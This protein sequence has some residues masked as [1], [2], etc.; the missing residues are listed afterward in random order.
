[1]TTA[2][3]KSETN[4][5]TN[6]NNN[7]N[8]NTVNYLDLNKAHHFT[9]R[10]EIEEKEW[11]QLPKVEMR[12]RNSETGES[13][14]VKRPSWPRIKPV[15]QIGYEKLFYSKIVD[16]TTGTFYPERDIAGNT[17]VQPDG[18][19]NA[20]YIVHNIIRLKSFSGQEY[21]Y[22]TGTAVGFN[23]LGSPVYYPMSK[24]EMYK[25][26]YWNKE[27]NY[28]QETGRIEEK[29]DSPSSQ[30]EVYIL[31]FSAEAV[32]ELFRNHT[33]KKDTPAVYRGRGNNINKRTADTPCNFIVRDERTNVSINVWWSSLERTLE[34]FK[35]KS[36]EYLF[37][38]DYIPDPVKAQLRS[39]SE[40]I[41]GEKIQ[42]SPKIQDNN[43]NATTN[44]NNT[45]V[46]K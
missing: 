23:S 11:N 12:A 15:D 31:P 39:R 30:Q 8:N 3:T 42:D 25:K 32:D 22:T 34:L 9:K 45:D 4:S 33:I 18:G 43:N 26:T 1:M 20:R 28:N 24:P 44:V 13:R 21:L 10:W 35:T 29:I 38:G 41:T 16:P 7:S 36:F 14:I 19:P 40:G 2:A 17:I 37:N 27:R 6:N 5:N 46:Y